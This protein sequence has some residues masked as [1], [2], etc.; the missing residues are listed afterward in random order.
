[1]DRILA[2]R[3]LTMEFHV[4]SGFPPRR[5]VLRAVDGIDLDLGQGETLGLVGESG[6]GK[7]TLANLLVRLLRPSQGRILFHGRDIA[8]LHGQE[9]RRVRARVQMV[10]QDPQSALDPRM[11]LRKI[12]GYPLKL[13]RGL[14][15]KALEKRIRKSLEEVGLDQVS[16]ERYPH[17]F[18]GG[19]RQR[20]GIARALIT[21][22]ECVILDEPTSALDVSVQAQILTLLQDLQARHGYG[23]LFISHDLSVVRF[24]SN[25]IAVMYL[26]R[27]VETG[28][29]ETLF[30][31]PLHPYTQALF[32]SIPRPDPKI[33]QN[34]DV[35]QT[36]IPS[37]WNRPKG[38]V[39]HPRC[40]QAMEICRHTP[41]SPRK[42]DNGI[43][44]SCHLYTNYDLR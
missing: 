24:I 18:S 15:G 14:R 27:I 13:H 37:P 28:P 1:M 9:M 23:Y 8:Q 3:D 35:L 7:S 21:Q 22:P 20:I 4:R 25:R 19:Q 29:T 17:E 38:C 43:T 30:A 31:H 11:T 2:T 40:A 36:D 5:E 44:V 6:S 26:G 42:M 41:P 10:F 16:L 34:L 39:F 33:R 12:V 32:L